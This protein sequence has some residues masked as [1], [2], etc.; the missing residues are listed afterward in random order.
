MTARRTITAGQR[1]DILAA[2]ANICPLCG[3]VINLARAKNGEAE[4]LEVDHGHALG[5]GG[6][7]TRDNLF[8]VHKACHAKK[9]KAD[10][11]AM[12]KVAR[13]ERRAADTDEG[14]QKPRRKIASRPLGGSRN[15]SLKKKLNGA[16]ERRP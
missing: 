2:Q 16:V 7:D 8:A 5:L 14:R 11:R 3:E 1:R 10:R 13:A 12:A 15:S 6:T 9:T 4:P